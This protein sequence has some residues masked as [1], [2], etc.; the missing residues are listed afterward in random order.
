MKPLKAE[1]LL[2]LGS[3]IAINGASA[4][5]A[6]QGADL[7]INSLAKGRRAS[8]THLEKSDPQELTYNESVLNKN[9]A[10]CDHF[11]APF[12]SA[13][14]GPSKGYEPQNNLERMVQKGATYVARFLPLLNSKADGSAYSNMMKNDGR[15][16]IVDMANSS[17]NDQIQKI[18]FFAQTTVSMNTGS[19]GD[20]GS[21]MTFSLDSLMK[22]KELEKDEAGDLKTLLFAQSKI[23]LGTK[24]DGTTNNYGLGIRHRPNDDSMLGANAFLDYRTTKY[25]QA[26]SRFGLGSE[27]LWKDFE[28][29]NNW[30]MAIT[31]KRDVTLDGSNYTERVVPG[32]DVELGYRL[33]SY[34]ELGVF[35]KGFNWDYHETQ[36]N[37]GVEASLNWQATPQVN[38]EAWVSNEISA[39][40]TKVNSTLPGTDE[41]FFGLRMKITTQPV[42][43]NQSN[44]KK[45]MIT[46]MTQPVRRRYDVLIERSSG[47]WTNRA[48]GS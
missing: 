46:Q 37:S 19:V 16:L 36:D 44:Y 15:T 21:G 45:N 12:S 41:T 24:S 14:L 4:A 27:Y 6:G 8:I 28:L 40:E 39:H 17:V 33:P 2:L 31:G 26:H 23:A 35:V 47:G 10:N 18:P 32:W 13:C 30:Y 20:A 9:L 29:R 34:P 43:Y 48:K 38:L 7:K 1:Q 3:V 22:L 5:Y 42:I 11:D 25:S